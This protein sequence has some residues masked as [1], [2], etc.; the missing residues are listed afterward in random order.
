M[1][2][3]SEKTCSDCGGAL[4]EVRLIDKVHGGAHGEVE[5]TLP[6]AK[7]SFWRGRF[8][9]EGKVAAFMCGECGRISLYGK[10]SAES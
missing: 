5:Y 9:V 10:P 1:T 8:P 3:C 4:T 6:D 7:R 2:T